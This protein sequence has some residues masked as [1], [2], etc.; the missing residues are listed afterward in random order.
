MNIRKETI[1]IM[2]SGGAE[3]VLRLGEHA[4]LVFHDGG[5]HAGE[6]VEITDRVVTLSRND[7]DYSYSIS[8]IQDINE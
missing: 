2:E 1:Y 3:K 6:L 8:A 5:Y 7:G 4:T